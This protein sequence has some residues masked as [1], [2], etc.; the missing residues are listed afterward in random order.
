MKVKFFVGKPMEESFLV[1]V[2]LGKNGGYKN[3]KEL[4][5]KGDIVVID[6]NTFKVSFVLHDYDNDEC[7]VFVKEYIW[8]D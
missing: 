5:R 4:P 7:A 1:E 2:E 3:C 8:G 6:D